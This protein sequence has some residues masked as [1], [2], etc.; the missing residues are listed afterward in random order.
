MIDTER[1]ILR[2]WRDT[3]R[4]P[5][6]AMGRDVEVMRYLGGIRIRAETDAAIDRQIALQDTLGHCFWAL[7]RREDDA[8]LGFCGL[9]PGPAGTPIEDEIEIGW[10]L[11]RDAWGEGYAREAA[12]ASLAWGWAN[13]PVLE[14]TAITVPGNTRSWGLMERLGMMRDAASDFDHPDV[15]QGDPLRRHI[16]YRIARLNSAGGGSTTR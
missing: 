9:K 8:F 16:T 6:Y 10:R 4:A 14:I 12:Q 5:F 3:D 11:R 2:G 1:L 7:E 13:L 15:A